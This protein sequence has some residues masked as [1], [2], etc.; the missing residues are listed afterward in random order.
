MMSAPTSNG[1]DRCV[2]AGGPVAGAEGGGKRL[3]D[4][5]R[6]SN[7]AAFENYRMVEALVQ[8]AFAAHVSPDRLA[9]LAGTSLHPVT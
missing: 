3:K 6:S 4:R 1:A 9:L 7:R 2:G 5:Q 8:R